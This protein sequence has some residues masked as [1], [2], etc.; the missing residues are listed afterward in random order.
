MGSL[1]PQLLSSGLPLHHWFLKNN[2]NVTQSHEVS[3]CFWKNGTDRLAWSRVATNL[4]FVKK[5]NLWSAIKWKP[6]KTRCAC[7]N[8]KNSGGYVRRS[9][10]LVLPKTS[11]ICKF[12]CLLNLPPTNLEGAASFLGLSLPSMYGGYF[13]ILPR[14]FPRFWRNNVWECWILDFI[15]LDKSE[16]YYT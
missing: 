13:Q 7:I 10:C 3:Q 12:P 6:K 16:Y 14:K 2:Q 15:Q 9:T 5:R 11:L 4:P 1:R 8:F